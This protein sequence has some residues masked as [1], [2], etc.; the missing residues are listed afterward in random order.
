MS[1]EAQIRANAKYNKLNTTQINLKFNV[2][3]DADIIE[4]LNKYKENGGSVRGLIIQ[5]LRDYFSNN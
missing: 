2:N 3:T 1:T 4:N 5:L